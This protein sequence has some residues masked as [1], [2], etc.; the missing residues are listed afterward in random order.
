MTLSEYWHAN[1]F[2][3]IIKREVWGSFGIDSTML[4]TYIQLIVSWQIIDL[5]ATT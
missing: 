1:M 2:R 4:L 5:C 3:T